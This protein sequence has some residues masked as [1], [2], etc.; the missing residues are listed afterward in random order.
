MEIYALDSTNVED[1]APLLTAQAV[2][3]ILSGTGTQGFVV[4]EEGIHVGALAGGFTD[5]DIYEISSMFVLPEYRKKGV[6]EKMLE[7]LYG[8]LDGLHA[9]IRVSFASVD[10]N[11]KELE[12]F[13]E[14]QGFEEYRVRDEQTYSVTLGA[15][16]K[17]RLKE[18]KMKVVYPSFADVSEEVFTAFERKVRETGSSFIP[19][20][21]GGFLS[22]DIDAEASTAVVK[23][24]K[25]TAYAVV[26]NLPENNLILS[27]LY[28]GEKEELSTLLRLLRCTLS[29]LLDLYDRD[30]VIF[31]PT[32][33]DAS[34]KMITTLF[35]EDDPALQ[36]VMVSYR[37]SVNFA[38]FDEWSDPFAIIEEEP[39]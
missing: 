2:E 16:E 3:G 8:A 34:E 14:N 12:T 11:F 23:D 26:E 17:T 33:T 35:E 4:K 31:L 25:L 27:S 5:E 28:V 1:F 18:S 22:N 32:A 19:I 29:R 36:D 38:P 20:P 9:E 39:S 6:G 37:K 7:T 21:L 24:G 13:L 10:S 30:T 15:L